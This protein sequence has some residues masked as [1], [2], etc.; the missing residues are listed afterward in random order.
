L[1]LGHNVWNRK[2]RNPTKCYRQVLPD[3]STV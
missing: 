2:T 3:T 1:F